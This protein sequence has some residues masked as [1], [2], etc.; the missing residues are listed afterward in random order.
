MVFSII[1]LLIVATFTCGF[2]FELR[3]STSIRSATLQMK[4]KTPSLGNIPRKLKRKIRSVE[5]ENFDQ[6]YTAEFDSF[7]KTE[8]RLSLS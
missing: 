4:V 1:C 7:L 3:R 2:H 6:L 5:A 8:G